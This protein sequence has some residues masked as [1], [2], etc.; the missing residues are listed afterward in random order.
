MSDGENNGW[1]DWKR[2]VLYQLEVN[3]KHLSVLEERV[4]NIKSEDVTSI[5][6][7]IAV[8]RNDM[9][10]TK[11]MVGEYISRTESAKWKLVAAVISGFIGMLTSIIVGFFA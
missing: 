11:K 5:K 1:G 9:D 10:D 2:L 7:D 4:E 6:T 3:E 8:L